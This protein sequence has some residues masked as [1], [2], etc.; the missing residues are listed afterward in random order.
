MVAERAFGYMRLRMERRCR[1]NAASAASAAFGRVRPR[2]A[3]SAPTAAQ[4]RARPW[5]RGS[6]GRTHGGTPRANAG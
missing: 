6:V 2:S 5:R 4:T 3:A 1:E